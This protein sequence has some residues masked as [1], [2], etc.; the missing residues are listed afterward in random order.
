MLTP[1]TY[2]AAYIRVSTD[3]Q[4]ELS[5]DAQRRLIIDY[6]KQHNMILTDEYIYEE[7]S[8]IS[9]RNADKRP[10]FQRMIAAAKQKPSPFSVILVWKFSRF[11]RNQEESIVYKSLLKKQC[12]V[13]VV[14]VSEPI[15]EGPF[16]PLIE[17]II[18]W[19]DEYYSVRLSGEVMRGMTEKAIRGGYQAIAP[20]GYLHE[21]GKVPVV[22]EATAPIVRDIFTAYRNGAGI[23]AIVRML[24]DRG[25]RTRQ[26]SPFEPRTVRYILQNPF[27]IGKVR[28]N[29][30]K[31]SSNWIP[32]DENDI[33][34]AEGQHEAIIDMETWEA[35]QSRLR[36]EVQPYRQRDTAACKHYLSGLMKCPVCGASL[37]LNRGARSP[38]FQCWKYTKGLH[39]GSQIIMQRS[40]EELLLAALEDIAAKGLEHYT[41][42]FAERNAVADKIRQKSELKKLE[43]R[44]KRAKL[45][46]LD[47]IDT[48]AEYRANRNEIQA[49]IQSV[50][51]VPEIS[52]TDAKAALLDRIS[53]V[54]EVLKSDAPYDVK[55]S[56]LRQIIDHIDVNSKERIFNV[57]LKM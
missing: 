48:L 17:R 47:G 37:S 54:L 1:I 51:A 6:A 33:I 5:P 24:N 9:G 38:Y 25:S 45:A 18:E 12:S 2:A 13:D 28:W 21:R 49:A 34:I 22:D 42:V 27:Y 31:H 15:V 43:N 16:G 23:V 4:E 32:N 39:K 30:T 35:V 44:L 56:S 26:G 40:A 11:A 19:M 3:R 53:E 8:G 20:I 52:E 14:S 10:Q 36:A 29:R 57:V 50:Q 7:S 55:G 41:V 46:Y